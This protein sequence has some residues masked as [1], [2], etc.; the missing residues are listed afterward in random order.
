MTS[1]WPELTLAAWDDTRA[2]VHMWTQIVGKVRLALEPPLNHWWQMPLYVSARGPHHV[3]DARRR[4]GHRDRVRLRRPR[5]RVPHHRRTASPRRAG[6][7]VG[8]RLLR[9]DDGRARRARRARRDPGAAGRGPRRDPVRRRHRAP[10]LRRATA[11]HRFWLALVQA[12]RV[13]REFRGRFIGKTSPVHFFWGAFDLATTRFSGRRAPLH[14]GGAPNCADWVMQEAYSHEV[15][16]CGFWPGGSEE[17]SFY[18]YA[19]PEPEGFADAGRSCPAPRTT[20]P[21]SASSC[22]RTAPCAPPTTPTRCCSRSC[23]A[24]TKRPPNRRSWDRAELEVDRTLAT[25]TASQ[26]G[27]DAD[28]RTAR[29]VGL[30]RRTVDRAV[31]A[32]AR[33]RRART[34]ARRPMKLSGDA[35]A[36]THRGDDE[37]DA[38]RVRDLR[39]RP[40]PTVRPGD[41]RDDRERRRGS[42]CGRSRCSRPTRRSRDRGRPTP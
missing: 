14:P 29:G 26:A 16:S 22:C 24:P 38:E 32:R 42:R 41:H 7:A 34:C 19:Y 21:R 37:R 39:R 28:R 6:T 10:R 9:G 17:G 31:E 2:T 3:A 25:G 5:A 40:T 15:S 20:T 11:M 4:P 33:S 35:A 23:R 1:A 18:A 36:A 13:L 12:D 8:R 27:G 30:Q